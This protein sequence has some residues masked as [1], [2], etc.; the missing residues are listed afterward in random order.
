MDEVGRF[1]QGLINRF[2]ESEQL[3]YND[4]MR[5]GT[6]TT[7]LLRTELGQARR[8]ASAQTSTLRAELAASANNYRY[9]SGAR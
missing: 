4:G 5:S 9:S 8:Q 6:T 3:A 1:E 7:T 2:A